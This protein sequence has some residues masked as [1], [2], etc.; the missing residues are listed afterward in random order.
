MA[1]DPWSSETPDYSK[2]SEF[3]IDDFDPSGLPDP[4]PLF[5]RGVVFAQRDFARILNSAKEI[6]HPYGAYALG[7]N[8]PAHKMVMGQVICTQPLEDEVSLT[9]QNT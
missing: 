2:L 8:T 3:G 4:P 1:I 6:R 7:Q 9:C 5:R